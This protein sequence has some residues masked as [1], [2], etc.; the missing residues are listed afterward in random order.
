MSYVL[1]ATGTISTM[2]ALSGNNRGW[3][4]ARK[5]EKLK[6]RLNRAKRKKEMKF[7][8]SFARLEATTEKYLKAMQK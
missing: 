1:T 2:V 3:N 5:I 7:E 8:K 4:Y 6:N